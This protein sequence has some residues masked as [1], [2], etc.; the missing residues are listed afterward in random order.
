MS[1]FSKI[2]IVIPTHNRPQYLARAI[3]YWNNFDVGLYIADS[4]KKYSKPENFNGIYFHT[5]NQ[6]F[7]E[8]LYFTLKEIKT[9]YVALCADDDFTSSSG[10][11]SSIK[12]LDKNK[13]FSSAQGRMV[14]FYLDNQNSVQLYPAYTSAKNYE[15]NHQ[16]ASVRIQQSMSEYMHIFYA[17]HRIESLRESFK[18]SKEHLCSRGWEI[19]VSLIS[20]LYGKHKT[21]PYFYFARDASPPNGIPNLNPYIGNWIREPNN[22]EGLRRWRNKFAQMYAIHE[23]QNIT[24]GEIVFDEAIKS[25][26]KP[27]KN[28]KRKIKANTP[29]SLIKLF[30]KFK[31]KFQTSHYHVSLISPED[32]SKLRQDLHN[33]YGYPWSDEIAKED[34]K[35]IESIIKVHK[36][37]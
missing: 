28:L 29:F 31:E 37:H 21:L 13:D 7:A 18:L 14:A 8:K 12:Y 17:V 11:I 15:I 24:I 1:V 23:N 6:N 5:P 35:L 34:W 30:H 20:S 10:L 3:E 16:K 26:V 33:E 36:I 9:P 19:G 32:C 4:S 25:Y 2:S 22:Q 27:Q